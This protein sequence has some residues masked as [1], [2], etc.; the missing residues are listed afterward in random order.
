MRDVH[1][2]NSLTNKIDLLKP[3]E[4][5]KV[6]IYVC[7]PTVY[8][9]PHIGNIRPAVV[10]DVL[11]RFL[12]YIGYKVTY[13]SNYTDVDDKIIN[14]AI[15]L[16]TDEKTLS[17]KYIAEYEDVLKS[18]NV[19]Q[20]SVNPRVTLYMP[21]IISYINDLVEK[22][23]AYSVNG[24]VYF[25]VSSIQNYG[26]LS[27]I[28]VDDLLVGA[29]IEENSNKKSPV[30]FA[31]WKKT[32]AGITWDSPWGSG[33]PGW[34]TEC[35][36]MINSIF[37][38]HLIDIHGG[39]FDL[40]FPHHENEMA[41]AKAHDGNKLANIWMH[42]GFLNIDNEKMSKS[43]GN[44]LLAKD[45]IGLYGG[46]VVRLLMLSAQYRAPLNFTEESVINCKNE[47]I[48]IKTCYNQLAVKLQLNNVDFMSIKDNNMETFLNALSDD[49]NIAN[50]M[51]TLFSLIKKVNSELRGRCDEHELVIDFNSM[52]DMLHILGLSS[53]YPVLSNED[54]QLYL[55]YLNLKKE[56]RF[57]ESDVIRQSLIAKKIL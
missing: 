13:V 15:A 54:K 14:R 30:D 49:L 24:D 22:N 55:Q 34:H 21:K 10:F 32:D 20:A 36:V 1:L 39:G 53:E 52:H 35:C 56:K 31:L 16:K 27:K 12:E 3:I 42:N 44:V 57:A 6:S 17:E 50:A 19:E 33:R 26:E 5:G 4:E 47:L 37:P 46:E 43:I 18:L 38:K 9:S 23:D 7:G 48:K 2:Y 29:R 8:N 28:N 40:K 51:S 11:R 25:K 45:V 41:Q